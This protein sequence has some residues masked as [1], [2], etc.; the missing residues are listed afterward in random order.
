M[1]TQTSPNI[2]T[3]EGKWLC[4]SQASFGKE[5][6]VL[7]CRRPHMHK[8]KTLFINNELQWK[9]LIVFLRAAVSKQSGRTKAFII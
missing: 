1:D 5:S 6:E 4:L 8:Y 9:F 3:C 2:S 7:L